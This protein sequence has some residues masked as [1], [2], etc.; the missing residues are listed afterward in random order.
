MADLLP[1]FS[2]TWERADGTP[3]ALNENQIR[4]LAEAMG[5]RVISV[6]NTW[7]SLRNQVAAAVNAAQVAAIHWPP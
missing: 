1:N 2:V 7:R 3:I 5:N 4:N 6:R